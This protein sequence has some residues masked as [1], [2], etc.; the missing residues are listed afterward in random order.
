LPEIL[1]QHEIDELLSALAAGGDIELEKPEEK[2]L[3]QVRPYDFKTANRFSKDQIRMFTQIFD[4][5]AYRLSTFLSATLRVLCEVEI[6][7]IE[8]QTYAEYSN[9]LP[10]PVLLGIFNMEP[11]DGPSLME[12]STPVAYELVSRVLGGTVQT[13]DVG[14]K[15]LTEIELSILRRLM[16]QM[17]A[18][19]NECWS[20][21]TDVNALLDRIETSAQFSQI[22]ALNEPTVIITMNIK[23][24][25]IAGIINFCIP[26]VATQPIAKLL[27]SK[28]W[29]SD[30]ARPKHDPQHLLDMSARISSTHLTLRAMFDPTQAT[31]G[32]ILSLQVGDVIR[33]DHHIDRRIT[34]KV[35]HMEKFKGCIGLKGQRVAIKITEV[36]KEDMGDD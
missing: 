4:D 33:V 9:S 27:V 23:M 29:R 25:K 17:L 32:D 26:H 28:V 3:G 24:D 22:T 34:V 13:A 7:S 35:E 16:E 12:I 11:L 15:Q 8:E 6:I 19:M 2:G 36:L 1:T 21:V 20:K 18:L 14:G 30:S 31:V 5:Y 10:T